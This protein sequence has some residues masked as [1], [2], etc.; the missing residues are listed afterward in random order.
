[1]DIYLLN[2]SRKREHIVDR[3][4]SFLWTERFAAIGDCEV[5]VPATPLNREIFV[6]EG[7]MVQNRS[8]RVMVIDTVED[9]DDEEGRSVLTVSGRS[10]E[11]VLTDRL[12]SY[13]PEQLASNTRWNVEGTPGDILRYIFR[14]ICVEGLL[15]PNDI[16]PNVTMDAFPYYPDG[17][18]AEPQA[19][20]KIELE[21]KSIYDVFVDICKVYGLGFCLLMHPTTQ[22]LHFRVLTGTNRTSAQ[23]DVPALVFSPELDNLKKPRELKSSAAYKN[24]AVVTSEHGSVEVYDSGEAHVEKGFRRRVLHVSV[25]V[26]EEDADKEGLMRQAGL[27]ELAKNRRVMA[28]D[29]EV[30]EFG[31]RYAE[32]YFLGDVVEMRRANGPINYMRATEQIFADDAEGER[33]YPTLTLESYI[34]PDAWY[35][36]PPKKTWSQIPRGVTWDKFTTKEVR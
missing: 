27:E 2:E 26:K 18:I 4:T 34:A 22:R 15:S 21:L 33:D 16:I 23:S 11:S 32:D 36:L 10:L 9:G 28:F 20:I 31:H 19:T 35:A 17:T 6:D 7:W 30:S 3:F 5:V 13:G 14:T 8:Y 24:V 12:A 1:M 29:G 25:S